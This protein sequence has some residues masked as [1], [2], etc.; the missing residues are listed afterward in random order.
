MTAPIIVWFRRDLRL[1]DNPALMTACELQQPVIPVFVLDEVFEQLGAAPKWRLGLALNYFGERLEQEGSRLVLRRGK[2]LLELLALAAETGARQIFWSR[3]YDPDSITR[4]T[5]V[6]TI[7]SSKD[8]E[9]RSFGSHLLFEPWAVA[10]KNGGFYGVYSPFWRAVK[11]REVRSTLDKPPAIPS[12][13]SWPT[14]CKLDD[15]EMGKSMHRGATVVRPYVNLGEYAARERL[16][17]FMREGIENYRNDRNRLD[18]SGTSGLSENLALGEISP[19]TC[20][21]AG[22][23]AMGAGSGGAETFLKE[24]VWREFAYH[25]MYHT[26]H[27]LTKNWKSNWDAFPW[28]CERNESVRAWEQGRTG[29]PLVDAAMREMYIT[30]RMHNR[31]RMMVASFLTKHLL[32]HWKLGLDWFEQCL[33]DWDPASNAMGWQWTA[34]CGPD[35]APYFRIFNPEKQLETYDPSNRYVQLWLAEGSYLP[36]ESALSYFRA[37][38]RSWQMHPDDPYP[39]AIVSSAEGR[40]RALDA[41][42]TRVQKPDD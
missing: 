33:I 36:S 18:L 9:A 3:A 10:T 2:A 4:D 17:R 38:P 28:N 30:G 19:H 5:E 6:K 13:I 12:P 34:G 26:P 22:V 14:S 16:S 42:S 37:I 39:T 7:L 23:K 31:G 24:L 20:W 15:W 29:V 40:K 35:A 21:H 32:S 25:L 27:I 11:D 8:I 41:F 1:G